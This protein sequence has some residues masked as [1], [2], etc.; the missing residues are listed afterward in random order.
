M[1]DMLVSSY[2]SSSDMENDAGTSDK[3]GVSG[4]RLPNSE[5]VNTESSAVVYLGLELGEPEKADA[6]WTGGV[7][8]STTLLDSWSR[9]EERPKAKS[10]DSLPTRVVITAKAIVSFWFLALIS[11]QRLSQS[12]NCLCS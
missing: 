12:D 2:Q 9:V 6:T 5:A 1:K 8:A 7:S 10:R 11:L 4:G 3:L